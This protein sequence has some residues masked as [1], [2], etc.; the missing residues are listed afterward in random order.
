MM[1]MASFSGLRISPIRRSSS[2]SLHRAQIARDLYCP[3]HRDRFVLTSATS[4]WSL[5]PHY[6]QWKRY[7]G[8]NALEQKDH[9]LLL[10]LSRGEFALNGIRNAD[11]RA[12][13]YPAK[14]KQPKPASSRSDAGVEPLPASLHYCELMDFCANSPAL[15]VISSLPRV[16]ESSLL[17]S[18][19][20]AL[21]LNNLPRS[22]PEN[23]R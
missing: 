21:M 17:C 20:V 15:I 10:A 11:L 19:R 13:L 9:A 6:S 7:R 8:L 16:A 18:S 5:P 14:L 23:P 3:G 22:R 12:L 2:H 1:S 4:R